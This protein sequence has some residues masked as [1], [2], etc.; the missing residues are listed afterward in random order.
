[1]AKFQPSADLAAAFI[2][3]DKD[4]QPIALLSIAVSLEKLVYL[5][6]SGAVTVNA[7]VALTEWPRIPLRTDR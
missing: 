5:L 1:M 7:D 3:V 6:E 2:V 4:V